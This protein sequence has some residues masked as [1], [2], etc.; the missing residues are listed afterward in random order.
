MRLRRPERS[1]S[2]R[3]AQ[4]R[5]TAA[6]REEESLEREERRGLEARGGVLLGSG[7]AAVG[8]VAT[9]ARELHVHGLERDVIEG[10]VVG[11]SVV[12]L[13]AFGMIADALNLGRTERKGDETRLTYA[14]Q[15]RDKNS[16]IVRRLGRATWVFAGSIALF[17]IA[18][19]LAALSASTPPTTPQVPVVVKSLQGEK[20]EP[21]KPGP[22]GPRGPEGP[23]GKSWQWPQS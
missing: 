2:P 15:I 14:A 1:I 18:L 3:A 7:A 5:L 6:G 16:I 13:V 11:G 9:A 8:L 20:G 19:I 12:M 17:L 22:E 10:L 21:G 4:L 23:P